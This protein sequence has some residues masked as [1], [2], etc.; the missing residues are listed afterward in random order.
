MK[1]ILLP[2]QI[3]KEN[4][5]YP[6]DS[7][8]QIYTRKMTK[9]DLLPLF[10]SSIMS[11]DMIDEL[12]DMSDGLYLAGGEDWDPA[13]YGQEKHEKTQVK[14]AERDTLEVPL[15]KKA[16]QDKKPMLALCRG[17]QGLAI[18]NGGELYQ[19]L[20]DTFPNESHADITKSYYDLPNAEKHAVH[21]VRPSHVFD[22]LQSEKV[23]VNS[24]HHQGIKNPGKDFMVVGKSPA[25]VAE[26]I[27]HK[28][29]SYFCIGVQSHPEMEEES[30]FESLFQGFAEAVKKR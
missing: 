6:T 8:E 5:K 28:D 10:A 26:I 9:Y 20:P 18:A 25:G 13:L 4:P 3:F 12:Y 30:F 14:E 15:I 19:H 21:I 11:G 17:C 23:K 22:L 2:F 1:K 29:T 27:E 24:Y 7:M 16:L